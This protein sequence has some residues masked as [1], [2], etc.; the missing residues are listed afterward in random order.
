[1][2]AAGD[3]ER[4]RLL[5]RDSADEGAP[6]AVLDEAAALHDLVRLG[7]FH[8]V[9]ER[10]GRL[11][12]IGQ[13]VPPILADNAA[14]YTRGDPSA[15]G[16]AAERFAASGFNRAA[17]SAMAAPRPRPEPATS[18]QRPGARATELA[19]RCE[20]PTTIELEGRG[21][22]PLTNRERDRPAGCRRAAVG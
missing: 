7:R 18:G 15:L 11:A 8:E 19:A 20:A 5:L 16:D 9:A 2:V 12:E 17:E 21:P 14:A 1:M 3:P 4:A 22:V 6:G 13:G 10:L